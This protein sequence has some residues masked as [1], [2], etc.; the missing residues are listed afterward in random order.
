MAIAL[1]ARFAYRLV[2]TS[3]SFSNLF[4]ADELSA[5]FGPVIAFLVSAAALVIVI[6]A[7]GY[8]TKRPADLEASQRTLI[9]L[10]PGIVIAAACF[11]VFYVLAYSLNRLDFNTNNVF[12]AA[13]TNSWMMRLTTE[14][15]ARMG[16]RAIHPLA[17][18]I[19]RPAVALVAVL[20]WTNL[21]QA[22]LLL[23]ALAG[24]GSVFLIWL[25]VRNATG[26]INHASLFAAMLGL[27][28]AS[29]IFNSLIETYIFSGFLLLLFLVLVQLQKPLAWLV[30]VGVATFG[31]T[32]SNLVQQ[33]IML[34]ARELNIRKTLVFGVL[35]VLI[36]FALT[37]VNQAFYPNSST[38]FEEGEAS[39]EFQYFIARSSEEGWGWR[40]SLIGA[41]M[42]AF[43]VVAPDPYLQV[44]NR[45]D[46]SGQFPKFNFMQA[47]RL[48]KFHGT[49]NAA[50]WVWLGILGLSTAAAAQSL[51]RDRLT[52]NNRLVLGALGCLAFNFIF[53]AVYGFEPFL[54]AADWNFALIAFV[55]LG[56]RPFAAKIW[57]QAGLLL[58]IGLLTLNNLSFVY[59]VLNGI[60]PFVP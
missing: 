1:L 47:T 43:S 35:V 19:L 10:L 31:I 45:D 40:A 15:G 6:L 3:L 58:L 57:F 16:M 36:G 55:A 56:S 14:G 51:V 32:I 44:Y 7:V 28:T 21:F 8:L 22:S 29:L 50:I 38:F 46:N 41:D 48:S 2:E 59:Q 37:F 60:S 13:D 20:A 5:L 54:Y 17:F 26:D 39:G 12:F 25:L 11:A 42:F 53:H 24:A 18:L 27:S 34:F 52:S 30:P 9:D 23:L 33:A 4:G 49:G